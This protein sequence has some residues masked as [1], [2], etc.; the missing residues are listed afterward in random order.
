MLAPFYHVG[1]IVPELG[2]AQ[3][4]LTSTL[5]LS[6]AS[7]QRREMPVLV[8]GE[9][10]E[11]NISFVYSIEGPPYI[12]L[13]GTN[14]PPWSAKVGLHHMGIWSEDIV[15]DMEALISEKYTVAATGVNR[16][17]SS[18]GF[19]YLSSPTGILLELVDTRGKE[20]FDRWLAGG[21]YL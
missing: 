11:L 15:A 2:Q 21:E 20:S 17:G 7:Q 6:W 8:N 12:E 13:I 18:G 1:L 4:D 14:E 5:G 9:I 16:R 19:A 10:V 3:R